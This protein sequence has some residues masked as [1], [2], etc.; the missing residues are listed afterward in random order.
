MESH[1][2]GT[3]KSVLSFVSFVKE[4]SLAAKLQVPLAAIA[5]R[6]C[7]QLEALSLQLLHTSTSRDFC[8]LRETVFPAYRNL[9]FA[10]GNTILAKLDTAEHAALIEESL[11]RMKEEFESDGR[12]YFGDGEYREVLFSLS[13][14]K[15][16]CRLI[17][18]LLGG[19]STDDSRD[20]ELSRRFVVAA[21]WSHMHLD[22]LKQAAQQ[23][24]SISQEVL[25]ELLEGSRDAVRAYAVAR[26]AVE[27]HETYAS[28]Y[29]EPLQVP[30]DE[31]DKA[32]SQ[33]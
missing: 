29:S 15:S 3:P 27:L 18:Q 14:L 30:W 26:E 32:L 21:L 10:L 33:F 31:E 5:E 25:Q 12:S 24:R 23:T 20:I 2:A 22:C 28:R 4:P 6:I 11:T 16:A 9:S 1:L 19:S 13:T 17:P 8:R 7:A